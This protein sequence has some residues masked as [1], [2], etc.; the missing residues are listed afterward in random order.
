[1][2]ELTRRTPLSLARPPRPHT[3]TVNVDF[4]HEDPPPDPTT[5][6]DHYELCDQPVDFTPGRRR[7]HPRTVW[8]TRIPLP[9]ALY[10]GPDP[11]TALAAYM[12]PEQP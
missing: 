4:I 10:A 3:T 7:Y 2:N 6:I 5:A 12:H 9:A 8:R 11:L 1:M